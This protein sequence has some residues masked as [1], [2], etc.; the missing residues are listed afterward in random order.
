MKTRLKLESLPPSVNHIYRHTRRGT[1]RT[2]AYNTWANAVGYSVNRQMAKQ[3][4]W[5]QPVYITAALRRPRTNCDLDN[6]LKGLADLLQA[7]GVIAND[8]LIYGWNV[9]WSD[10]LPAGTAAE[11]S[12][13]AADPFGLE[14][15]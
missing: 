15:A 13:T 10:A 14:A 11:I 2:E 9:Y 8:K 3:Q 4:R 12:I 1:F 7:H 5:S 6:R